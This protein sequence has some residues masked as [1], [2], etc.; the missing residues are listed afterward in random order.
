MLKLS[1]RNFKAAVIKLLQWTI[2]KTTK[3]KQ[4]KSLSKEI[5]SLKK[6]M[7]ENQMEILEQRNTATNKKLSV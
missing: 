3:N 7:Q 4:T 2:R 1:D 6:G 5:Q